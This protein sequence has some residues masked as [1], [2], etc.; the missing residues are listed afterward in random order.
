MCR[1]IKQQECRRAA[2]LTAMLRQVIEQDLAIRPYSLEARRGQTE[3]SSVS[4]AM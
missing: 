4:L 1:Q 3:T 2:V